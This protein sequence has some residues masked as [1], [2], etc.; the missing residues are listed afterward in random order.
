MNEIVK[1]MIDRRSIRNYKPEQIIK[2]ELDSILLAGSYAP[3]A[4]GRQSPIIA[5]CQNAA[6]ND[7]L[8]KINAEILKAI[9]NERPPMDPKSDT[10]EKP[11]FPD[12][13]ADR[14]TFNGAPTVITLFAPK[15][16]Y[17]FIADCCV[18]AQNI[19]LAA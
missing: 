16:W 2:E 3:S 17:N 9:F 4:G 12:N 18:T 10:Q 7:E 1:N 11:K 5:V 8:G 14:S 6:L 19:M 13:F 15:D